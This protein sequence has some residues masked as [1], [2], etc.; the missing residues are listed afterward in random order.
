MSRTPRC[1]LPK[2]RGD[3]P[4]SRLSYQPSHRFSGPAPSF[5]PFTPGQFERELL[6]SLASSNSTV[7][8]DGIESPVTTVTIYHPGRL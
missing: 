5:C 7:S 6:E 4:D 3:K 2:G 8:T 1:K